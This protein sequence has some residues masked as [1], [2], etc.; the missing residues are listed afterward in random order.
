MKKNLLFPIAFLLTAIIFSSC[1]P[2]PV[3]VDYPEKG[4]YGTNILM[5]PHGTS[6]AGNEFSISANVNTAELTVRFEMLKESKGTWEVTEMGRNWSV[7]PTP[8]DKSLWKDTVLYQTFTTIANHSECHAKVV[9][10]PN[11]IL[12][13]K[14]FELGSDIPTRTDLIEIGENSTSISN[15]M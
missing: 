6:L 11:T 2:E 12:K 4:W 1:K 9:F 5:Q 7:S 3:V 8:F 10:K 13:V 14:Y 15:G